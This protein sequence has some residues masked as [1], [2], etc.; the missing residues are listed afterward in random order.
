MF[1]LYKK[2]SQQKGYNWKAANINLKGM[3]LVQNWYLQKFYGGVCKFLGHTIQ[4]LKVKKALQ[5]SNYHVV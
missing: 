4:D 2:L 3:P 5:L 1:F